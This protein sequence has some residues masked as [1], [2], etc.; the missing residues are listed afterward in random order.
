MRTVSDR[1]DRDYGRLACRTT[2]NRARAV[3]TA[4]DVARFGLITPQIRIR[5]NQTDFGL[6]KFQCAQSLQLCTP[7]STQSSRWYGHS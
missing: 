3:L 5:N 2:N 4:F 7:A 6:R 1:D